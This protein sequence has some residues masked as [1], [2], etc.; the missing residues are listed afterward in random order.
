[1]S[2]DA[3]RMETLGGRTI[4]IIGLGASGDSAARL[5]LTLGGQVYVSDE[6]TDA[7]AAARGDQ[8][9]AIGAATDV[10]RH[11]H[12][13]IAASDI[14]VASPGIPPDAP[15]L[16]GLR[17]RGVRW[18][19]EP[20]FAFR[21]LRAPLIA[22]TGT[23]GKTTTA[24]LT[25]HL[26]RAG[27]FEVGLGG[28]IGGGYGPPASDIAG[29]DPPPDWAVWELSSF[30][31]AGV[32]TFDPRVGVVTNLAPDHL[33]RYDSV[34]AY[35]SD[36]ARL[37][38]N[39]DTESVWVL[40]DEPEVVALSEGALGTRLLFGHEPAGHLDAWVEDG[41]LVERNGSIPRHVLPASELP[42]L[43]R[44]NR[45]NAL[46]ALLAA[47]AAGIERRQAAQGLRGAQPLAHRLEPVAEHAG[48]L[49]VNDSKA[50]NVAAARSGIESMDRPAV[51]LLGG[52]DKGESFA[53]LRR[54][55]ADGARAVVVYGA[56]RERLA[57]EL[58][59]A[60]PIEVTPGGLD[61]VVHLARQLARPGDVVLLSPACSSFDMFDN[62]EVRGETFAALARGG[63]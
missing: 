2:G 14:V 7:P 37:F 63:T 4:S 26:L 21:F 20:E 17:D 31:L 52:K 57:R 16:R 23:N 53:P 38:S 61:L 27:G 1:M 55:L 12:D 25:A 15:V 33:D 41:V 50:T 47:R 35:Y 5:A 8:L 42:L 22:I 10:G 40:A 29:M 11:D 13:R 59:G 36:K 24:V 3:E 62:Y 39:S 49:W 58:D 43:G 30:Q 60:C 51:V 45:L 28:N 18:I 54:P 56:V 46:A 6:N 19:S 32:D 44:H 48:V 34:S 9:R